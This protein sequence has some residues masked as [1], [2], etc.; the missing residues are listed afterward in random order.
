MKYRYYKHKLCKNALKRIF[1]LSAR[2]HWKI[3]PHG[4]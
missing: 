3:E 4:E 2:V 1:T